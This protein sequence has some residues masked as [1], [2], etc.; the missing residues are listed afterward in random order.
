MLEIALSSSYGHAAREADPDARP[1]HWWRERAL[2]AEVRRV[3][4]E[5]GQVY[6]AKK[7]WK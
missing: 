4:D 5:N 2:E 6:G 3:W 7:V 1:D